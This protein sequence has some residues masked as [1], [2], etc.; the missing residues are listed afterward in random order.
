MESKVCTQA[1]SFIIRR[2]HHCMSSL[3][4]NYRVSQKKVPAFETSLHQKYF[5]DLIDSTSSKKQKD[6]RTIVIFIAVLQALEVGV[7]STL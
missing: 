2:V 4:F 5:T 3:P 6:S 1:T 7:N